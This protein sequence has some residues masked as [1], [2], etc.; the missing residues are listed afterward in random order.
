MDDLGHYL[1]IRFGL[2]PGEPTAQQLQLITQEITQFI[3]RESREPSDGELGAIVASF[4][5]TTG[6]WKYGA[7][8]NLEL[9]RQLALLRA[10][11]KK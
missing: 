7:D 8:V 9:R 3:L 1:R 10:Q 4:C 11:A 5:P 2:A 6:R